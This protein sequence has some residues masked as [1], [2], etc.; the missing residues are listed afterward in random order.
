MGEI[1]HWLIRGAELFAIAV[2]ILVVADAV[3]PPNHRYR[4]R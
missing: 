3:F 1:L 2:A 4:V